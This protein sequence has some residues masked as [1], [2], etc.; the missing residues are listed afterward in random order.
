MTIFQE[1]NQIRY[2]NP[3][4]SFLQDLMEEQDVKMASVQEFDLILVF[5]ME[6]VSIVQLHNSSEHME[7]SL[8]LS[9]QKH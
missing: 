2:L 5:D 8:Y 4:E 1:P 3:F 7:T 9:K 6:P